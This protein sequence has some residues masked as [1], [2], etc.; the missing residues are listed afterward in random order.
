[1]FCLEGNDTIPPDGATVNCSLE[2]T[3]EPAPTF[4]M[5]MIRVLDNNKVEMLE[6][7][8]SEAGTL[9]INA[10]L[11]RL[12]FKDDTKIL[13]IICNVSNSFGSD[14]MTTNITTCGG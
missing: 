11:L 1:M 9:S 7:L 10:S 8:L 4:N 2:K 6:T 3:P 5:T 14:T 13:I 12:L